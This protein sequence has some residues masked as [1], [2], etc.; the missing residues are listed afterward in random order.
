MRRESVAARRLH[1]GHARGG[2]S[3]TYLIDT[4]TVR[5]P[6][7]AKPGTMDPQSGN[8]KPT[9]DYY[10]ANRSARGTGLPRYGS[11]VGFNIALPYGHIAVAVGG[12]RIATTRGSDGQRLTNEIQT[13]SSYSNYLGWVLP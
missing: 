11:L 6:H 9:F 3:D 4:I 12:N 5:A 10:W 7:G 1:R 8:A 13:T 2:G